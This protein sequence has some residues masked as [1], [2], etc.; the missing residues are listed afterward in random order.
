MSF[1]QTSLA[2]LMDLKL[3]MFT[4]DMNTTFSKLNFLLTISVKIIQIN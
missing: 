4:I 3:D 2:F 1:L